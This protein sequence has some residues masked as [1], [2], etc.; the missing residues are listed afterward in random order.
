MSSEQG[1]VRSSSA[2][3]CDPWDRVAC[4]LRACKETQARAWGDIDDATLG[5]Y[6]AGEM[7]AAE[8]ADLESSLD[9]LPELRQL[10]SLVREVLGDPRPRTLPVGQ[11]RKARRTLPFVLSER[12]ALVAAAC[13][14][15]F[16]G[17]VFPRPPMLSAPSDEG[18]T[19][20]REDVAMR[21][22]VAA[23]AAEPNVGVRD[24]A[25]C[26][27]VGVVRT[28]S[29][30]LSKLARASG[31]KVLVKTCCAEQPSRVGGEPLGPRAVRVVIDTKKADVT[32][33]LGEELRQEGFS[34]DALQARLAVPCRTRQFDLVLVE[35]VRTIRGQVQHAKK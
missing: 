8:L 22:G 29:Q 6:L 11:R 17:V 34:A 21:G 20:L 28:T 31:V 26:C 14:I 25:Q 32:V 35:S 12:G 18:S 13:V 7:T 33:Q 23:M 3:V 27:S 24:E 30:Q 5:R 16:L 9:S 19:L 15:V 2:T 1:T 4:E 10:T